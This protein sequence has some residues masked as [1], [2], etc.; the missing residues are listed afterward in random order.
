MER[1]EIFDR[2]IETKDGN[3]V[4]SGY[5]KP[6][7]RNLEG[8]EEQFLK[9][10]PKDKNCRI[11]DIGCGWGQLLYMLRKNGYVNIEGVDLG[12]HQVEITKELG[13]KAEKISDLAEFLKN[14]KNTWDVITISQV[15]EHFPKDKT[16]EYL[17]A[18]KSS[19]KDGGAA[20]IATP[21][22]ALLSGPIQRYTDFTHET[23]FTERSLEQVLRVSGF[24]SVKIHG[25]KLALKPRLKFI[26]WHVLRELWFRLLGF[27]YLLEK[28]S[29][30]P[31]IISRHL[32]ALA[33]K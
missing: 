18:V 5:Q 15:I 17:S 33:G 20:I 25:E 26:V 14:N 4:K 8:F 13:I 16:I 23:G 32:I 3:P 28:G 6:H 19:L 10:L 21:N 11:L 31:R 1:K 7:A 9:L 24:S 30:R 29:D 27:I 12:Y 2:Y 22:M